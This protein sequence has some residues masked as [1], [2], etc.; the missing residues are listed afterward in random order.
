MPTF[1]SD[2]PLLDWTLAAAIAI[3]FLRRSPPGEHP[4]EE[5]RRS[6]WLALSLA[7][8]LLVSVPGLMQRWTLGVT[9]WPDR[10]MLPWFIGLMTLL[11]SGA[12]R[13]RLAEPLTI[14]GLSA[15]VLVADACLASGRPS[16]LDGLWPAVARWTTAIL[17]GG[18]IAAAIAATGLGIR[19]PA[20]WAWA[21][22]VRWTG[23]GFLM[24]IATLAIAVVGDLVAPMS[25]Y[26][27][28][29]AAVE[30]R[31]DSTL[32]PAVGLWL[33]GTLLVAKGLAATVLWWGCRQ[34]VDAVD[35]PPR[36]ADWWW[37]LSL[38]LGAAALAFWCFPLFSQ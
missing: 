7:I 2:L 29:A 37:Q 25:G 9:L 33:T 13:R 3:A 26:D 17:A 14:A 8:V 21:S 28:T 12:G 30:S 5:S 24:T 16:P 10:R 36:R 11:L 35:G 27:G 38:A 22:Q 34:A 18:G 31:W 32:E 4:R 19:G 1:V 23:I 15:A 6:W 20:N